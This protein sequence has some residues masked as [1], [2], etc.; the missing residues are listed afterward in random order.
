LGLALSVLGA[1]TLA[2]HTVPGLSQWFYATWSDQ[3]TLV[4]EH[5]LFIGPSYNAR[6]FNTTFWTLIIEMRVSIILPFFLM[7]MRRLSFCLSPAPS[8][9][10]QSFCTLVISRGSFRKGRLHFCSSLFSSLQAIS[11]HLRTY[12]VFLPR[13]HVLQAAGHDLLSAV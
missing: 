3:L 7:L 8:R 5:I 6:E 10:G 4:L 1:S 11:G 9:Q 12:L 13:S 2:F